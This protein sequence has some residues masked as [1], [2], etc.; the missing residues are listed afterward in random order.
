[1]RLIPRIRHTKGGGGVPISV[2]TNSV[3]SSMI[4]ISHTSPV[5]KRTWGM[6]C[7]LRGTRSLERPG[8]TVLTTPTLRDEITI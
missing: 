4:T 6:S 5:P 8:L 3:E 7:V 1:M 2:K